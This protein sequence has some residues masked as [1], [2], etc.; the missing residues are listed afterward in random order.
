MKSSLNMKLDQ[1]IVWSNLVSSRG[2]HLPLLDIKIP[3]LSIF[4]IAYLYLPRATYILPYLDLITLIWSYFRLIALILSYV[5]Y[6]PKLHVC[7]LLLRQL[8]Y[9]WRYCT[10]NNLRMEKVLTRM[11][12][13]CCHWQFWGDTERRLAVKTVVLE[14]WECQISIST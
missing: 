12:F 2:F 4:T 8:Q 3:F 14:W 10:S 5:P 13:G 9:V 7:I 1:V 11:Q 6:S